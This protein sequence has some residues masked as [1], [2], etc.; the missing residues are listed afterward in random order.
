MKMSELPAV[1]RRVNLSDLSQFAARLEMKT[2][3]LREEILAP[4]PRKSPPVFTTSELAELCG[5]E[6]N[7]MQYHYNRETNPLPA[8]EPQGNG[9]SRLFTLAEARRWVQEASSIWQSPVKTGDGTHHAAVLSTANFK[10]GSC[11]TTTAMCIAQGLSLRG[12]QVL[13]VDLDPQASLSE[14]CGLYAEKDV[15]WEDTVL[16]YIYE[17][18]KVTLAEKVQSTYWDGIDL[19]PA[20]NFM[21][22]A[23]FFIP[24]QVVGN[25]KYEFWAV[26]RKGL[27]PLRSQYD[28]IVLDSAPSLSYLTMNGMIAADALV[29]P[30]VPESLDFI[31]SVSFWTLFSAVAETFSKHEVQKSYDFVS[32]LLSKVDNAS[33]SS[34]HIVRDWARQ[35]YEEW[36][37]AIEIPASSVMSNGALAFSTVFDLSR[38]DAVAKTLAR[39]RQPL[40][41]Y[42]RWI[43]DQ[44]V[45][46]WR[47]AQ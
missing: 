41:D 25:S 1:D 29:M 33:T 21:H 14:L 9:R 28:Y 20:N 13:L 36:L 26:L 38:G 30:L 40:T 10:G 11:K 42:C 46:K 32:V 39:I 34:S 27:E 47:G 3:D 23:E 22:D 6:R 5:L 12:R 44:Y 16:P 17:P 24:S 31:S 37:S 2:K 7:K 4:R 8:G 43:D 15:T 18:D 35:A 19:I 45:A